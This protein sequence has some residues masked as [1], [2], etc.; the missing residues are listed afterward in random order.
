MPPSRDASPATTGTIE[1]RT[2][3]Q[4]RNDEI[5]KGICIGCN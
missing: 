5:S 1:R 4:R 3:Q 2:P